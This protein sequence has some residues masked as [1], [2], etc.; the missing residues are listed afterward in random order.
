MP[1]ILGGK[2]P[3][4]IGLRRHL[5]KNRILALF[6]FFLL[7][8]VYK[9]NGRLCEEKK[10]FFVFVRLRQ[11]EQAGIHYGEAPPVPIPNTEVKLTSAENTWREAAWEDRSM[12]AHM[13]I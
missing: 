4:K 5:K 11:M 12:P 10:T 13:L 8:A 7:S 1:K 9:F 6:L 2:L 3:G